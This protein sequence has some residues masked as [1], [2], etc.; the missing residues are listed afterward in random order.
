MSGLL[1]KVKDRRVTGIKKFQ[2]ALSSAKTRDANKPD[3]V[4]LVADPL[5]ILF[6]YDKYSE[7]TSDYILCVT[8]ADLPRNFHKFLYFM[9][10]VSRRAGRLAVTGRGRAQQR[11]EDT[12]NSRA[13]DWKRAR[14][15]VFRPIASRRDGML[16]RTV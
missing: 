4:T 3:I 13:A 7:M 10:V 12:T 15:S 6:G 1:V 16:A 9:P 5:E 14:V 8:P 11:I 2:P